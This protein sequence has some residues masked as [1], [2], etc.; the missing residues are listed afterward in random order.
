MTADQGGPGAG[1]SLPAYYHQAGS[2]QALS[3]HRGI[4]FLIVIM[5]ETEYGT[6]RIFD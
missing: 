3:R 5:E 1:S 4:G 6:R 2:T